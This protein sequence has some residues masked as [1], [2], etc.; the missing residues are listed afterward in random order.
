MTHSRKP[1]AFKIERPGISEQKLGR[2]PTSIRKIEL[3]E[4]DDI[5]DQKN[6]L[7]TPLQTPLSARKK[8]PWTLFLSAAGFLLSL[9]VGVWLDALIGDLFSR[10]DW[11][12]YTAIAALA[13]ALFALALIIFREIKGLASLDAA[14]VLRKQARDAAATNNQIEARAVLTKLAALFATIP[15]T[16]RARQII[17]DTQNDIVDGADL[18]RLAEQSLLKPMDDIARAMILESAKRVSIVTA[19]S[20][21]ALVDVAYVIYECAKLIRRLAEL[22]GGR[23]STLGLIRLS[24]NAI[25]H[26]AVT[27]SIAV[28]DS[29]IQQLIGHGMAAKIS[30]RL[31]EG[32]ING[33]MTTRLGIS[34]MDLV[35]PMEFVAE[36]RPNIKDFLAD[37]TRLSGVENDI[38]RS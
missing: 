10:A 13:L 18:I 23:P 20:P 16:A 11:L 8:S 4:H 21:R 30:A 3:V 27:G 1:A 19:V 24:K 12:G 38:T 32:V 15:Q 7:A 26:L 22:Y 29:V 31:G 14:H 35:R 28:G 9:A 17:L 5:F 36:K 33:L 25:S 34:A 6:A 37:L 2:K